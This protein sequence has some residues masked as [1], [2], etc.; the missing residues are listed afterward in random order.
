M[1]YEVTVYKGILPRGS[2]TKW[3]L[4]YGNNGQ[5]YGDSIAGVGAPMLRVYLGSEQV[6]SG[7]VGYLS[8]LVESPSYWSLCGSR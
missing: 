3:L 6:V 1:P 2:M 7:T 8:V 5:K 4:S